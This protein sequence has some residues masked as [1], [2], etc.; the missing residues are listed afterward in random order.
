MLGTYWSVRGSV[1]SVQLGTLVYQVLV[2]SVQLGFPYR[3]VP[4]STGG[5]YWY[6]DRPL[7]GGI[8]IINRRWSI[9]GE[10]EHRRSIEGEKGK[11]KKKRKRRKKKEEEIIP[12]AVLA[13]ALSSLTGRPRTV[14]AFARELSPPSLA[15]FLPRGEKD[16]GDDLRFLVLLNQLKPLY[17]D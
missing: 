13:C 5:T 4:L 6:A 12:H 10:I 7:L 3:S 15:I 14:V 11:K 16:R 9:D 17:L 1:C 8:A 2:Y